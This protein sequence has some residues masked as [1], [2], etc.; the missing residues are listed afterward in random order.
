M[1]IWGTSRITC[2]ISV[3]LLSTSFRGATYSL[4]FLALILEV[5]SNESLAHDNH[6]GRSERIG[7]GKIA[8]MQYR[9]LHGAEITRT[10]DGHGNIRA[11][12]SLIFVALNLKSVRE[13]H[14][15]GRAAE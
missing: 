11:V 1:P 10:A 8:A 2:Q 4:S 6:R 13:V 12:L 15:V 5:V 3:I 7:F 14:A 9:N